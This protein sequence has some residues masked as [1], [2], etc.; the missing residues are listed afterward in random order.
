M[1]VNAIFKT[2]NLSSIQ[3][4]R[5]LYSDL[6]KEAIQIYGHDVYYVDRTTV[7][8]D[9]ILGEDSLSKFTTQHP[10]IC[11]T[12][13]NQRQCAGKDQ[14]SMAERQKCRSEPKKKGICAY[15]CL[16]VVDVPNWRSNL[17][18]FVCA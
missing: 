4:E 15:L 3:A 13:Q 12:G 2:N 14:K 18:I 6:I 1:A 8:I 10:K 11:R 16:C 9:T 5:N 7:A 17:Y